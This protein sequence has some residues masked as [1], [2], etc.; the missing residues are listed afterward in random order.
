M[1][2]AAALHSNI[3]LTYVALVAATLAIGGVVLAAVQFTARKS[4]ASVWQTYRG[5]VA[6]AP[7]AVAIVFA[8]RIIFV[9][10]IALV[11]LFAFREFARGSRLSR[12]R[13]LVAVVSVAIVAVA[14]APDSFPLAIVA[15][16]L[17]PIARNTFAGKLQQIALAILGFLL[18]GWMFSHL[19]LL[20]NLPNAYGYVCFVIFATQ[21]TDI[22]AFTFGRAFGRRALRSQISPRKTW[23]GA[24]AAF[25]VS[26]LLPWFLHF[27]FPH[28]RATGLLL[29][30]LIVGVGAQLGDLT[31][32]L[33]KRDL[34]LKDM[35]SAIPGHGGILDR[36]DSLI[37]VAPL[38][39]WLANHYHPLR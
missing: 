18:I 33:F 31:V 24:I 26:M 10:S 7:L 14:V 15:I 13:W 19:A 2:P 37:F 32:S 4:I 8:G 9:V 17:V 16:C 23:E 3:F 11:S 39:F 30:G 1:S 20:A 29:A 36:I 12:D 5:W 34:G 27:S 25:G 6:L 21:V 22:A 35:G 28:F 38:F